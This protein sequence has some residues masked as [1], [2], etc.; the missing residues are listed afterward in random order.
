MARLKEF[1]PEERLEKAKQLFWAK[2]YNATSMKDIVTATKLNPGSIYG[3]FG[4]KQALFLECLKSYATEKLAAFQQGAHM[5]GSPLAILENMLR[6]GADELLKEG[7]GCMVLKTTLELGRKNK[8][9]YAIASGQ[10]RD[11]VGIFES[12]LQRAQEAGEIAPEK[13]T[14]QL[15]LHVYAG[16]NGLWQMD[17]LLNERLLIHTLL[18][19]LI[20]SLKN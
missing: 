4:G 5:P 19:Q 14:R 11:I 7:K 18:D 12:L 9:A 2:G 3:T 1:N 17:L 10:A 6:K 16:Y 8:K 20:G 13:D 15:A